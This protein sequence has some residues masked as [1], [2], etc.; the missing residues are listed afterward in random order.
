MKWSSKQ[1]RRT[2]TKAVNP[3]GG[4]TNLYCACR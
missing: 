3:N 2:V 4:W 1:N